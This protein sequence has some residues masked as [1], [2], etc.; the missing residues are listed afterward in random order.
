LILSREGGF[1]DGR[2]SGL[3]VREKEAADRIATKNCGQTDE[4]WDWIVREDKEID[5][6]ASLEK[7]YRSGGIPPSLDGLSQS[8]E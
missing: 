2:R 3:S 1:G 8:K 7:K 5:D 6:S 4:C